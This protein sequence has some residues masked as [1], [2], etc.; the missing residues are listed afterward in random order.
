M[1]V[2]YKNLPIED[3]AP[4]REDILEI[5]DRLDLNVLERKTVSLG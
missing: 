2:N 1:K 4:L 3:E 5:L